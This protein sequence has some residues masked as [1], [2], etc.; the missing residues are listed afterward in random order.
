MEMAFK[1]AMLLY[2]KEFTYVAGTM[3]AMD[4]WTSPQKGAKLFNKTYAYVDG[5]LTTSV[6]TRIS[7]AATITSTYGYAGG[8]LTSITRT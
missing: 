8:S 4:I 2:Y 7:D 3:T 1:T 6:L 5:T